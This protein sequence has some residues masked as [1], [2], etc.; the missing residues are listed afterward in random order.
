M[1]KAFWRKDDQTAW[2]AGKG[3]DVEQDPAESGIG[4]YDGL[5]EQIGSQDWQQGA[6]G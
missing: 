4:D 5:G 2:A 1:P 6:M 3:G